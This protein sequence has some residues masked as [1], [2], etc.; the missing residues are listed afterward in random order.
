MLNTCFSYRVHFEAWSAGPLTP[1]LVT[2][3]P[4]AN[5]YHRSTTAPGPDLFLSSIILFYFLAWSPLAGPQL[6]L[7]IYRSLATSIH[8]YLR[9]DAL[10]SF[11]PS[12]LSL[13]VTVIIDG[14][15]CFARSR[16]LYIQKQVH[17]R[18]VHNQIIL[19]FHV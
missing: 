1:S 14:S 8:F 19:C 12:L 4:S 6:H 2:L 17:Y 10:S 11:F 15:N 5:N 7:L 16:S 13:H 9:S 3:A 18:A